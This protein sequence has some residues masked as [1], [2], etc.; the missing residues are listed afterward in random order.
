MQEFNIDF[1]K[2]IK[3]DK[4]LLAIL[5]IGLIGM[6]LLLMTEFTS[7]D[8]N[9]KQ[10]VK[11]A[12]NSTQ[13]TYEQNYKNSVQ[14]DLQKIIS[15]IDGA[16][17]TTVMVTLDSGSKSVYAIDEKTSNN[18]D[19]LEKENEYKKSS[20]NSKNTEHIIIKDSSNKDEKGLIVE[21]IQ[22]QIRGVAIVCE[23]ADS[24]VVRQNITDTVTAVLNISSTRVCI[25]KMTKD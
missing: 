16:G 3:E 13:Y 10:Q 6:I 15:S 24:A 14:N 11:T 1:F 9:K 5:S 7:K 12:D 25:T 23:G 18:D 20:Q 21:V 22:P 4:K 8:K 17:K 2:K 19:S